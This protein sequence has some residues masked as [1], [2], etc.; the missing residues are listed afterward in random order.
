MRGGGYGFFAREDRFRFFFM[1]S[2][3]LKNYSLVNIFFPLII[4]AGG[5]FI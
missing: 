2:L 3:F 1:F 5:S 4:M